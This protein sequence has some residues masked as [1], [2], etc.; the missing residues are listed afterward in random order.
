[1]ELLAGGKLKYTENDLCQWQF[2]CYKPHSEA[3]LTQLDSVHINTHIHTHTFPGQLTAVAA[4]MVPHYRHRPLT[5]SQSP[6][7]SCRTSLDLLP[8]VPIHPAVSKGAAASV[9]TVE[10]NLCP[11]CCC[12]G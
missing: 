11:C 10:L 4:V 8:D 2:T 7:T 6:V 3:G 5:H 1:M 9:A 12:S